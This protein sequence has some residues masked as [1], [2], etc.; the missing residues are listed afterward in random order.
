MFILKVNYIVFFSSIG[1][2]NLIKRFYFSRNKD[3]VAICIGMLC[4][5]KSKQ[6]NK[7]KWYKIFLM[8]YLMLPWQH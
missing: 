5:A 7:R 8:H 2:A 3:V 6:A 1:R 4:S